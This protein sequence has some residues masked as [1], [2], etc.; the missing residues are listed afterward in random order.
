[1]SKKL[2]LARHEILRCHGYVKTYG[3]TID[4]SQISQMMYEQLLKI[5][6]PYSK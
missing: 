3:H 4:V 5:P 1:M 2:I 6:A